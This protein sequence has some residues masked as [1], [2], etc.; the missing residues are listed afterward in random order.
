MMVSILDTSITR[1]IIGNFLLALTN[2]PTGRFLR[3]FQEII[4]PILWSG[5]PFR[6]DKDGLEAHSTRNNLGIFLFGNP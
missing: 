4:S 2:S 3:N 6:Q 5:L 1:K